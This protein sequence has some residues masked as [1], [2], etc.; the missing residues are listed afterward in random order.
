[1]LIKLNQLCAK[2]WIDLSMQIIKIRVVGRSNWIENTLILIEGVQIKE[3]VHLN[4]NLGINRYH[5][6]DKAKP[7]QILI[8]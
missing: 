2:I 3:I 8:Q 7:I 1:M 5:L 6:L 4:I